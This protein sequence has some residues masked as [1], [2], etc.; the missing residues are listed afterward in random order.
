MPAL[1]R[2]AKR[3]YYA[4]MGLEVDAPIGRY[5]CTVLYYTVLYYTMLFVPPLLSLLLY[6]HLLTLTLP[7]PDTTSTTTP[8][9]LFRGHQKSI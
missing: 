5:Y 4:V 6:E 9:T 1:D 3:D 7:I 2:E 8:Y